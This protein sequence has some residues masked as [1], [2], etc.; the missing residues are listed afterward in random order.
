MPTIAKQ[1]PPPLEAYRDYLV[2]LA[3]L[4]IDPRLR[5]K[6][7]PSDVVQEALLRAHTRRD[8]CRSE[9]AA[10]IAG[11]LRA[12]LENAL[13]EASRRF[14][15]PQRDVMREVSLQAAIDAFSS[16][17]DGLLKGN[18]EGPE[19]TA[20]NGE[21]LLHLAAALAQLPEDQRTAVEMRYFRVSSIPAIAKQ[22]GRSSASV[23]GLLRRGLSNLRGNLNEHT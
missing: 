16:R 7:D 13:A 21:Q 12:I 2:L 10:E 22:L 23:A 18:R 8:Q 5:S 9:T 15:G 19:Q 11:W 14:S 17:L 4:Q 3:R 20:W 6:L 1:C